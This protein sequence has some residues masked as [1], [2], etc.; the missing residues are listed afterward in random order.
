MNARNDIV[1]VDFHSHTTNSDGALTPEELWAIW[2]DLGLEAVS[3]TDHDSMWAYD[4]VLPRTSNMNLISGIE[5]T[6]HYRQKT[7]HLLAFWL[8]HQDSEVW[9]FLQAQKEARRVRALQIRELLNIDLAKEGLEAI[10]EEAI[11]SLETSEWPITR[12]DIARYLIR[13]WYVKTFE[14]AFSKWLRHYEVPLESWDIYKVLGLIKDNGW[15]SILAHPFAKYVSVETIFIGFSDQINLLLGFK[16]WWLDGFEWFY[17]DQTP[18]ESS[19]AQEIANKYNFLLTGGSDFH[20]E[21]RSS[22]KIPGVRMPRYFLDTF[23]D[24]VEKSRLPN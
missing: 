8:N 11:L 20:G 4:H 1:W 5:F 18:Y 12:P 13:I 21:W 3:F 7:L 16:K 9:R 22:V 23:L 24:R 19:K 15:V 10:S 17:G 14:E 2:N 6:T